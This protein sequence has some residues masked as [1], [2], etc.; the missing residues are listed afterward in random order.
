MNINA[1]ILIAPLVDIITGKIIEAGTSM[2]PAKLV[3]RAQEL[4][5][6]NTAL[7]EI[8]SGSVAGLP[9][10]QAAFNTTALSPGE[11]LALQS[12]FASLS[13]QLSLLTTIAGST[14]LGQSST[15]ILDAIL[16]TATAT[17]RAYVTKYSGPAT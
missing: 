12:L 16:T 6:V 7:T 5:A 1:S 15:I 14:L 17:A 4:I 13:T 8:N 11:A 3:A 9:A 10:L 2:V